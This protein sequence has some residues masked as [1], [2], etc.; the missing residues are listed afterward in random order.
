M[1]EDAVVLQVVLPDFKAVYSRL[2]YTTFSDCIY[3]TLSGGNY[4]TRSKY[5][6]V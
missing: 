6:K 5:V 4:T 1:G 3:T 2:I